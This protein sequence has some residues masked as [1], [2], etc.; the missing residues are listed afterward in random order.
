LRRLGV[1]AVLIW[2]LLAGALPAWAAPQVEM[3]VQVSNESRVKQGGWVTVV[4]DLTNLGGEMEGELVV[5]STG[6]FSHPQYLVPITLPAGGRKRIPVS[7]EAMG[8]QPIQVELRTDGQV[9][10]RERVNLIWL[11]PQTTMIGILSD[12]ELGIPALNQLKSGQLQTTQVVRLNAATFPDRAALLQGYDAIALSRFDTSTLS[13]EQLRALEVWVGRGGTLLLAGGP[14]WKRTMAALPES[15]LPVE[16]TG[17]REVALD[18]LAGLTTK[19][20]SGRGS[21]SEAVLLKGDSL[22]ESEGVPLVTSAMLGAG[23]IVYVA[24]DPGLTPVVGWGGQAELYNRVLVGVG[25]GVQDWPDSRTWMLQEALKRIPDW[26]LPGVW[27]IVAILGSYMLLVGPVTYL[28]LKRLDR[29]EWGWAVIP[30]LSVLFV[31]MVY[32]IGFGRVEPLIS[33]LITVTELSPGT[34]A[35]TMT[36]YVGLYAPTRER[37]SISLEN[38]KLVKPFNNGPGVGAG[39]LSARVVAGDQTSLELLNLT[40]YSMGGFSMEHDIAVTGGLELVDAK[41]E[42]N[43]LTGR[44]HNGL[45][46]PVEEVVVIAGGTAHLVQRLEPGETSAE[47]RIPLNGSPTTFDPRMGP[48]SVVIRGGL[49]IN[50]SPDSARRSMMRDFVIESVATRAASG[51]LLMGWANEP[52][53]AQSLPELGKQVTG[54]NLVYAVLPMPI[55]DSGGN[56]PA[57]VVLGQPVDP[58]QTDWSSNGYLLR[59]GTHHFSLMLPPLVEAQVESVTLYASVFGDPASLTIAVKNQQTGE[60]RTFGA[61]PFTVPDWQAY[62]TPVGGIELRYEAKEHVEIAPPTVSVKGVSR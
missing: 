45:Q 32:L 27:T 16:V 2:L 43:R 57:G 19:E 10:D 37:L 1:W 26:G 40:N 11:A 36:S 20:L 51:I 24:F 14:E 17:V 31:G 35:G 18:P 62:L 59:P 8:N 5:E 47:I 61:A 58:K 23:H 39:R 29:R 41:L 38:A 60:W 49:P 7:L 56:L 46:T 22:V 48:G 13:P 9:V 44:V 21:V 54:A 33:H 12:D 34:K 50:E 15:L 4:V 30:A 3:T 42:A 55:G 6:D 52:P 53:V 25:R 28:V